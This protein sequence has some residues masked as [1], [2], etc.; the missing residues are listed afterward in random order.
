MMLKP[1]V[2]LAVCVLLLFGVVAPLVFSG[3]CFCL[4]DIHPSDSTSD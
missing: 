3:R 1:L 4:D 2:P